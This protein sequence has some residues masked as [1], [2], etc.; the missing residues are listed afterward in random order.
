MV[1][2]I[3]DGYWYL[4]ED[5]AFSQRARDCGFSIFA[6]TRIRLWHV[7]SYRYG[8]EEAGFE[9]RRFDSFTLNFRSET[10]KTPPPAPDIGGTPIP[11]P[12]VKPPHPDASSGTA[13]ARPDRS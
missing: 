5:Y 11:A 3:E 2:P 9:P 12:I 7:G 4:A 1:R 6:D 8:W 10:M 13:I